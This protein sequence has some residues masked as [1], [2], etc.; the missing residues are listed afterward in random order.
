MSKQLTGGKP[1]EP[2]TSLA[3]SQSFLAVQTGAGRNLQGCRFLFLSSWPAFTSSLELLMN[4]ECELV[5]HVPGPVDAGPLHGIGLHLNGVC[6]GVL[7]MKES[8]KPARF[9]N[10]SLMVSR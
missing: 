6:M 9:G 5:L 2:S 7:R 10:C 3:C 8:G 1:A 4:V